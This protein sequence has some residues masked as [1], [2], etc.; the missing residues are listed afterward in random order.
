MQHGWVEM[1]LSD[2]GLAPDATYVVEDLLDGARYTW[3][4]SWNYVRLDPSER[5]AHVFVVHRHV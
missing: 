5:V 1:P 4:G 2:I 3:H